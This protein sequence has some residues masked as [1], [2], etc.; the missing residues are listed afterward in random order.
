MKNLIISLLA[1]LSAIGAAQAQ[2]TAD[3]SPARLGAETTPH[4]YIGLGLGVVSDTTAGG[5]RATA[6]IFGG[7]E[8][9]RNWGVEA[10]FTRFRTSEF[11]AWDSTSDGG[12]DVSPGSMKTWRSYAAGKYTMP[13]SEK[14]SAFGKFGLSHSERKVSVPKQGWSYTDRDT[15]LYAGLGAQYKLTK[16]LDAV[17]EYERYGK[18]KVYGPK[19]DV[20][21]IGL[22]YG[23]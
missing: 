20:Y 21:S 6:K 12:F 13:I 15:G 11:M 10:G 17:V 23:F 19:A 9:N 18:R 1:S 14:F 22:K 2:T 5:R 16:D 7:Y 4:A 8:F 3:T